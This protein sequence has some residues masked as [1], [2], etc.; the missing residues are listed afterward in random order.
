MA[1]PR[2]TLDEWRRLYQAAIRI[3]EVAPWE[4]MEETDIFGV[5][6]PET[7]ELGFVSVMGMLG[8]HLALALYP[9]AKGLHAF[10]DF[11]VIADS[12]PPEQLLELA[13]LQASFEDR[14][15]VT[16]EDRAV[17]KELGLRFRGRGAWPLF[18]SYRPGFCPWYLEP[19]EARFLAYALEQAVDVTQRFGDNPEMLPSPEHDTYLVRVPRQEKGA[20]VWEDQ[21]LEVP[22]PEPEPISMPMDIDMLRKVKQLPRVANLLEVDFFMFPACVGE[23]G[24]RPYYPYALLIV[25]SEI[26]LIMGTELL[27]PKPSLND[28]RGRVPLTLL[29]QLAQ[30]EVVPQR[31]RVRSELLGRLLQPLAEELG[32]EIE[33]SPVLPALDEAREEL[34]EAM[35]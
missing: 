7:G 1:E 8:E 33:V 13:H 25:E 10:W 29:R 22:A 35:T 5:Q 11:E 19:A 27:D 20:V 18:R 4:W 23:K 26:G 9:G 21:V 34:V 15:Y 24:E 32:V 14:E 31:I 16:A 6:N 30:L 3:K 17:I 12:A 28:M 2:P